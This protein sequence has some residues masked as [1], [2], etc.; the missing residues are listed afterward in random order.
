MY[1]TQFYYK[2]VNKIPDVFTLYV[3][4]KLE[5]CK[6]SFGVYGSMCGVVVRGWD[7]GIEGGGGKHPY[8]GNYQLSK[9]LLLFI[10]RFSDCSRSKSRIRLEENKIELPRYSIG[11][12]Q[13][14]L[15]HIFMIQFLIFNTHNHN[16]T[17]MS[18]TYTTYRY[19]YLHIGHRPK[20]TEILKI[21][22]KF[23][24]P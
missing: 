14:I 18:T 5:A 22:S 4:R 13:S 2:R 21:T 15:N 24:C 19:T 16:R 3:S 6:E 11:D 1:F 9:S 7:Q 8:H 23:S 20:H 17:N 10:I 12:N